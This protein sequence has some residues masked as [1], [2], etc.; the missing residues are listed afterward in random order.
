MF[1][2]ELTDP[3]E[4]IT[5]AETEAIMDY[6]NQLAAELEQDFAEQYLNVALGD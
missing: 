1:D 3:Y 4:G 6:A 5:G 2:M